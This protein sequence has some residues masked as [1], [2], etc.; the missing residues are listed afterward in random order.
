MSNR[1][2]IHPLVRAMWQE[3][4]WGQR[5][6]RLV[7]EIS[8][9]QQDYRLGDL[10]REIAARIIARNYAEIHLRS[11]TQEHQAH[12]QRHIG[13]KY[14]AQILPINGTL[15]HPADEFVLNGGRRVA[16]TLA[17]CGFMCGM[18]HPEIGLALAGHEVFTEDN[19]LPA[20]EIV[21]DR[22]E[23]DIPGALF[24]LNQHP[25]YDWMSPDKFVETI[26][27]T[28]ERAMTEFA[29]LVDANQPLPKE[30]TFLAFGLEPWQGVASH[31][32]GT[33]KDVVSRA[34]MTYGER[35]DWLESIEVDVSRLEQDAAII[36]GGVMDTHFSKPTYLTL[37]K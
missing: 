7:E 1:V 18:F 14:G 15:S 8:T 31:R 12:A 16:T 4:G 6:G 19:L 17:G 32:D 13:R 3:Q 9:A 29:S 24:G 33:T 26:N 21:L 30:T 10:D 5:A 36:Y 37:G 23:F 25:M 35:Y 20:I 11:N 28:V 34:I 27:S 22:L 2:E